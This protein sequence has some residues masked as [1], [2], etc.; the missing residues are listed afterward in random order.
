MIGVEEGSVRYLV[1]ASLIDVARKNI[2]V[3]LLRTPVVKKCWPTWK[4]LILSII[5]TDPT[6]DQVLELGA[7]LSGIFRSTSEAGRGQESVSGGGAAW[8][9]LV[10]FYLNLC[11]IG[12]PSVAFKKRSSVPEPVQDALTMSYRNVPANTE[13]DMVAITFPENIRLL[14]EPLH[15]GESLRSRL[16]KAADQ[17]FDQLSVSVVQCKTNWNDNAQIPMLWDMIY[18]ARNF[19]GGRITQGRNNRHI[20]NLRSFTYSFA[21]VPTNDVN[22]FKDTSLSVR[23]V[24]ELSGGNYWGRPDKLGVA[25]S[26]RQI[27]GGARI[28]PDDGAGIR[29]SLTRA[30]PDLHSNLSYFFSD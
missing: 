1:E 24:G 21:T 7:H 25:R 30:L 10:C 3:D 12:S 4:P 15:A 28:G 26:I 13:S 11:L 18:Q 19:S 2:V 20:Q 9:A 5:G 16:D 8:E 17:Y 22:L 14:R 6:A 23:R 29:V 27:F